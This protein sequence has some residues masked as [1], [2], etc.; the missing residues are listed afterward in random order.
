MSNLQESDELSV[1]LGAPNEKTIILNPEEG[2][3]L[4]IWT[5]EKEF[6]FYREQNNFIKATDDCTTIKLVQEN[7]FDK[8]SI[9][10][11]NALN[12]KLENPDSVKLYRKM[13]NIFLKAV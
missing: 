13:D 6:D 11:D 9:R 4:D 12:K 1:Q 3:K 10:I 7:D 2:R 8:G 5:Q